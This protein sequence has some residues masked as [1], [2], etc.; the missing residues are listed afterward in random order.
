MGVELFISEITGSILDCLVSHK[1]MSCLCL[2]LATYV[3]NTMVS[4]TQT[5]TQIK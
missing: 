2:S 5:L 3:L 4:T 1:Q